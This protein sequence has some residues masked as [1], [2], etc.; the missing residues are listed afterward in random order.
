MRHPLALA[1][2]PLEDLAPQIR[3]HLVISDLTTARAT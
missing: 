2:S 3:L 1:G